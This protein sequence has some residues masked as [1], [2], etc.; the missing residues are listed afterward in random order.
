MIQAIVCSLVFT[1]GAGT[2]FSGPMNS[3]ISEVYRRVIRSSSPMA[4]LLGVADHS[5]LGAAKRDVHDRALPGHPARQSA[6]FVERDLGRVADAAFAG[7]AC[8]GVLNP[9]SGENLDAA[10][11]HGDRK[12]NDNFARGRPEQLPKSFIQIQLACCKIKPR[13]L[14]FPR[15]NLLVQCHCCWCHTISNSLACRGKA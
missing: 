9:E 11:V 13:A 5:A 10:V 4:H 3:M 7:T 14:R 2:S 8:N 15:V 1:S 6:H 12:V